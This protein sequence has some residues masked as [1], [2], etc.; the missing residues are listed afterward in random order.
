MTKWSEKGERGQMNLKLSER[1]S[2]SPNSLSYQLLFS[3][4]HR[5]DLLLKDPYEESIVYPAP[6]WK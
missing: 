6:S 2:P 3:I 1:I 4:L 5:I